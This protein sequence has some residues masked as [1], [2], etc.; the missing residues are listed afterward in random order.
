M[1]MQPIFETSYAGCTVAVYP[2]HIT[3]KRLWNKE[4]SLPI[5][6]ISEAKPGVGLLAQVTIMTN[7]GNEKIPV[8][9]SD[10]AKLCEAISEAMGKQPAEKAHEQKNTRVTCPSCGS[11]QITAQKRGW[12]L[13]TGF[14]GSNKIVVTCI[15][16]GHSFKPGAASPFK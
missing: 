10:K 5:N 4:K 7:A 2:D 14:I 15:A 13:L 3:Y 8:K 16:C 9:L 1:A 6:Q 11:D 12:S